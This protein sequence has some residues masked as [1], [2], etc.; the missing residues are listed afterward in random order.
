MIQKFIYSFFFDIIAVSGDGFIARGIT[1][2]N[3]AGPEKESAVALRSSSDTSIFFDCSFKGYQDTLYVHTKRQFYRNCDIYGTVDI[4][5]GDAAAVL[6]NCNIYLRKPIAQQKNII[7]A[8]GRTNPDSNTGIVVHNSR[9]VAGP[10]LA[11][12]VR[13]V[14]TYLGRPWKEYSRTVYIKCLLG[15]LID[16]E[17]WLPWNGDFALSTLYYGEYMNVGPGANTGGRVNWPGYHPVM[18]TEE[19][20]M[21]SVRSILDGDSWL[22]A[23]GVPFTSVI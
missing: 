20:E 3:T 12:V 9:V 8:Q 2:E 21:F 14:K 10:E 7:T 16:P 11:P 4:I 15:P 13:S 17:G 22:P 19:A 1:F 18:S 6:Q 23:T 5:F